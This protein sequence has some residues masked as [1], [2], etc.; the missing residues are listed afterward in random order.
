MLERN[1]RTKFD[2]TLKDFYQHRSM[3]KHVND[4]V[5]HPSRQI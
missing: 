2:T 3:L 1:R 5:E 4:A